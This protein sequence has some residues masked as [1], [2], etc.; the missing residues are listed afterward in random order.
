M[1][2]KRAPTPC[3]LP[4]YLG[5]RAYLFTVSGIFPGHNFIQNKGGWLFKK[6]KKESTLKLPSPTPSKIKKSVSLSDQLMDCNIII[7]S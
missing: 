6:I 1:V 5:E 4:N 2:M 3:T 7:K